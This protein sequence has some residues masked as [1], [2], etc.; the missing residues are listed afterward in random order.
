[1]DT[2]I[3]AKKHLGQHFLTS[4]KALKTI[5]DSADLSRDDLVLEIGPGKGVLTEKLLEKSPVLAIEKDPEMIFILKEKFEKEIKEKKLTLLE[6]DILR[7][8]LGGILNKKSYKV[9]ANIPYYIT[10]EILRLFLE[11]K[12]K[13]GKM[14]LLV[15]KEVANRMV[16]KDGKNSILSLSVEFFGKARYIET[17][18]A[19]SF[20]PAPKVDSA[21]IEIN[22]EKR[23]DG[24]VKDFFK[25]IKAGFAHKR[26]KLIKNLESVNNKKDLENIFKKLDLDIN[27]RAENL[28]IET[29]LELVE[30]LNKNT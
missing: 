10:G 22:I 17:I 29:W 27:T 11:T 12:N 8:D 19:G 20:N 23:K 24:G 26:K 6:G 18:K 1:M 13:P 9:V 5:V 7:I 14:I 4:Q 15:Q 30:N 3:K 21:I 25:M 2:Q 16:K 28:K